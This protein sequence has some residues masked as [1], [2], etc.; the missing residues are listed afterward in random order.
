MIYTNHCRF[1]AN[2]PILIFN[3][4]LTVGSRIGMNILHKNLFPIS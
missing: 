2:H 4:M 3:N 1:G